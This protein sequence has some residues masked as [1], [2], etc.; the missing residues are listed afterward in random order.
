VNL[1]GPAGPDPLTWNAVLPEAIPAPDGYTVQR[2]EGEAPFLTVLE[3]DVAIG[4]IELLQFELPAGFDP[5]AGFE[6]LRLWAEDF[7]ANVRP[8]RE[9]EGGTFAPDDPEQAAFGSFC[10]ASYWYTVSSPEGEEI[11]RYAG[12]VT[13]DDAKL[14]L[15]VALYDA[16]QPGRGFSSREALGGYEP[17]LGELVA[18]LLV[19]AP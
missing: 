6:M 3:G 1:A 9:A 17:G 7:Y 16:A 12:Y 18:S 14:Y 15:V 8:E 2:G 10:G 11:E 5:Q 19:P 4:S 13:F